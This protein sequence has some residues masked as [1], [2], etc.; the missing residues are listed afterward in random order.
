MKAKCLIF[1]GLGFV[2]LHGWWPAQAQTTRYARAD[3][4][5]P[6]VVQMSHAQAGHRTS[7]AAAPA[8]VNAASVRRLPTF[9]VEDTP[10]STQVRV[11][12]AHLLGG[13]LRFE[14]FYREISVNNIVRGVG[15]V[16]DLCPPIPGGLSLPSAT[17]YGINL[18][19]RL[20]RTGTRTLYRCLF[21]GG[22]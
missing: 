11:P 1:A 15:Q 9:Y 2:L 5:I 7:F 14:A 22:G 3:L 13:R 21:G 4:R 17:S 18:S 6:L 19:I 12:V 10:F 20:R 16:S 8:R